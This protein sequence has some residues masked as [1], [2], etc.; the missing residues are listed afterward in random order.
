M[1]DIFISQ[2]TEDR[3]VGTRLCG[4]LEAR[5]LSCWIAPRD[6]E[7]GA[8]W[9]EAIV[10]AIHA[11]HAFLLVLSAHA[12]AS[13]YVKNE[14][15]HPFAAKRTILTFRIEDVLPGKSARLLPCPPSL[16]DGF[17]PPLEE[18]VDRLAASIGVL[19]GRLLVRQLVD[20]LQIPLCI[21]EAPKIAKG[22]AA[23]LLERALAAQFRLL[24]P[25][26]FLGG[27]SRHALLDADVS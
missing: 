21:E 24:E 6:V 3:E 11:S 5:G 25:I 27:A 15:N 18:K 17:P 13:P 8:E 19:V 2:A 12:N 4:L 10:D 9:D 26:Q 16:T 1:K 14:V 7:A 22:H 20:R 23:H